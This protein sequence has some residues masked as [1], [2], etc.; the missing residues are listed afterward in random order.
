MDFSSITQHE[1]VGLA[2]E[3]QGQL[4]PLLVAA[5]QG[6][7]GVVSAAGQPQSLEPGVGPLP[8]LGTAAPRQPGVVDEMIP[9]LH[10]WVHAPLG[11]HVAE[12]PPG[13]SIE[14]LPV[15]GDGPGIEGDQAHDGPHRGGLPGPVGSQEAQDLASLH[16]EA[17]LIQG[18]QGPVAF[19]QFVHDQ[20]GGEPT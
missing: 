8:G 15:P 7:N 1:Q 14:Q 10:A 6:L 13:R 19:R 12:L 3:G 18:Q 16:V 9:H 17:D 2:K 11:R 20:H 5:R 4:H